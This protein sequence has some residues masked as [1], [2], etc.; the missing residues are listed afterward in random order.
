[1]LPGNHVR[2]VCLHVLLLDKRRCWHR[3]AVAAAAVVRCFCCVCC[4]A[5]AWAV[6]ASLVPKKEKTAEVF[7]PNGQKTSLFF[8]LSLKAVLLVVRGREE[9][10]VWDKAIQSDGCMKRNSFNPQKQ[11][12]SFRRKWRVFFLAEW[13]VLF[14]YNPT[15]LQN[16]AT[17]NA[18]T[19]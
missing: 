14:N 8:S 15:S 11:H 4:T 18:V 16:Q 5:V 1:M 13:D 6:A 3:A 19:S 9:E 2:T 17:E 12:E 10:I 7:T